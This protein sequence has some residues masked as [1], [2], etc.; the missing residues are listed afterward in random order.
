MSELV[1][2]TVTDLLARGIGVRIQVQGDSMY[3]SIRSGDFL[4]VAPPDFAS[5]KTGDVVLSLTARGL[6]AHRVVSRN[7]ATLV[8][9]GDNC[10]GEDDP[11]H[12]RHVLGKVEQ[13]ERCGRIRR[14]R[15]A[16]LANAIRA[17]RHARR[18]LSA[19]GGRTS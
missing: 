13:I 5:L 4:H 15:R 12:E 6:T 8:T 1:H 7:T 9:R 19:L 17:L 3:P 14:V 11:V 18:S 10:S 16:P 2:E